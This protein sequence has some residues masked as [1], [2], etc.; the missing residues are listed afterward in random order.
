MGGGDH[1]VGGT[2]GVK[3]AHWQHITNSYLTLIGV[4]LSMKLMPIK[5][6]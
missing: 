4:H 1:E 5:V 2:Q 6:M 3:G